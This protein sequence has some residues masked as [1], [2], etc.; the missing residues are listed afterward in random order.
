MNL[1]TTVRREGSHLVWFS[2]NK[3]LSFSSAK[4]YASQAHAD[5]QRFL[6]VLI[7]PFTVVAPVCAT[8]FFQNETPLTRP[9][10]EGITSTIPLR[11]KKGKQ[12]PPSVSSTSTATTTT[13]AV[14][15]DPLAMYVYPLHDH[16]G[17]F[18]AI[19]S[20]SSKYERP[21]RGPLADWESPSVDPLSLRYQNVPPYPDFEQFLRSVVQAN[22]CI[23]TYSIS[24]T[25]YYHP[26]V[27]V[28]RGPDSAT[29]MTYTED[30]GWN[31]YESD[32]VDAEEADAPEEGMELDKSELLP[33]HS[34]LHDLGDVRTNETK[35]PVVDSE[36]LDKKSEV[37]TPLS[38]PDVEDDD[39]MEENAQGVSMPPE[40]E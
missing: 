1:V 19:I 25:S 26:W 12:I 28:L 32:V 13:T 34:P 16:C 33:V 10:L 15:A 29:A 3:V 7:R 2:D 5:A 11:D 21:L 23:V 9:P 37:K 38:K 4:D 27:N 39:D 36:N 14:I 35:S 20:T 40:D 17:D 30:E 8:I 6:A 18:R 24:P 31:L 22:K